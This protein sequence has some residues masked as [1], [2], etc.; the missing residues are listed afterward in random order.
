MK[1]WG[2]AGAVA[3]AWIAGCGSSNDPAAEATGV[4][5]SAIQGGATD[6]THTFAVGVVQVMSQTIEFCSGNLLTPNLVAT[7]RHCV[8]EISS[9]QIDCATATFG[10]LVQS[11]TLYVTTDTTITQQSG[12]VGVRSGGIYVPSE[13]K[14]CGNDIALLVLD[15]PINLPGG[16]PNGYVVPAINPPL[17]DPSRST[18]ITAIGY[19]IDTPTDDSGATAGTRRIKEN[20]SLACIPNDPNFTDCFSDPSAMQYLTAAEFISGDETTCEGD[21][22]SGVYDQSQFNAGKWVSY[23]VLS[24]GSVSADGLDCVQPIY[25]R[26][27]AWGSLLSQA[28]AAAAAAPD[29]GGYALPSWATAV[30]TPSDA[31]AIS[32]QDTGQATEPDAASTSSSSNGSSGGLQP[33]GADGTVC[34]SSTECLSQNCV[35]AGG[36]HAYCA[37]PCGVGGTCD[38]QFVCEGPTGNAYCFPSSSVTSSASS[39]SAGSSGGCAVVGPIALGRS[40]RG[41]GAAWLLAALGAVLGARGRRVRGVRLASNLSGS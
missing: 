5:S 38:P 6:T 18:I 8:A 20:V 17:T 32:P 12:F 19:G 4:T 3:A 9:P 2:C 41:F 28:A 31:S 27:D 10:A 34:T 26:F 40:G 21:S 16:Y 1:R 29:S 14:V 22:G 33:V 36:A 35:S 7:A 30:S 13:S 39:G 24:R 23:G 11:S 37:S 15:Q 25:T